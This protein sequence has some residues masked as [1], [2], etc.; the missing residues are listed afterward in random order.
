MK[1]LMATPSYAPILGG[2]ETAVRE[3]SLALRKRGHSVDI[4][5]INMDAKWHPRWTTVVAEEQGGRVFRWGA[6]NPTDW[7]HTERLNRLVG[8]NVDAFVVGRVQRLA[9]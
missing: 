9:M 6:C 4:L 1:V 5:T 8:R 2:T 7:I 3:L